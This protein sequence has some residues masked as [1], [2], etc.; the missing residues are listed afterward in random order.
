MALVAMDQLGAAT[1]LV[2]WG[3]WSDDATK[4]PGAALAKG[5]AD[6]VVNAAARAEATWRRG[7]SCPPASQGHHSGRRRPSGA[8]L[9]TRDSRR[10][11]A[12][13]RYIQL[14]GRRLLHINKLPLSKR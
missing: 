10:W 7:Q 5:D 4:G 2:A 3:A 13:R 14:A 11:C 12:R 1:T 6:L 8:S 9:V